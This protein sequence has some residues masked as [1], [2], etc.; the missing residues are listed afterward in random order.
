MA[1]S[2]AHLEQ[3]NNNVRNFQSM[4]TRSPVQQSH[5]YY[6]PGSFASPGSSGYDSYTS[7]ETPAQTE[8]IQVDY[9]QPLNDEDELEDMQYHDPPHQQ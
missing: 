7:W 6:H 8:L 4:V 9:E 1:Q 2:M 5:D 3:V